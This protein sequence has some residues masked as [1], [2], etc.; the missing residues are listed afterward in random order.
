MK[1]ANVSVS[2]QGIA[3][4]YGKRIVLFVPFPEVDRITLRFGRPDHRPIVSI[5]VGSVFAL[6]GIY[7]A[8]YLFLAPS[9][10]RYELGMIAMGVIGVS[11]IF[12]ALK[13][14][15]FF[16]IHKK[17]GD[18]RF[19]FSRHARLTEIHDFCTSIRTHYGYDIEQ[20]L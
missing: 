4:T 11:L 1:Y 12:D 20:Q 3:E 16:E 18:C 6:L 8:I 9:G 10:F 19:I 2:S 7:G 13:E 17:K 15:Y 14:R 5:F